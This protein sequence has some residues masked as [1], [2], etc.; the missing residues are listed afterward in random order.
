MEVTY[1]PQPKSQTGTLHRDDE[2][3]RQQ[4]VY[5]GANAHTDTQKAHIAYYRS[6]TDDVPSYNL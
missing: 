6:G 5:V 4:K 3:S 1:L 2:I